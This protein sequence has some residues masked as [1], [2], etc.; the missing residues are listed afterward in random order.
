MKKIFLILTIILY[1]CSYDELKSIKVGNLY[2]CGE[3]PY[4]KDTIKIIS[5]REDY[6]QYYS[7]TY[8]TLLV[9]KLELLAREINCEYC[10]KI[11]NK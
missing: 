9:G 7:N 11:K 4:E 1:S 6:F 10:K 5:I 2:E 3:N 8:D